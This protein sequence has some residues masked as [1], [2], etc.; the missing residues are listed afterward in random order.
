MTC[1]LKI[2]PTHS[3]TLHGRQDAFGRTLVDPKLAIE[4]FLEKYEA[5]ASAWRA[6]ALRRDA[7]S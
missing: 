7:V 1:T 2:N 4:D 6:T 5:A 3:R